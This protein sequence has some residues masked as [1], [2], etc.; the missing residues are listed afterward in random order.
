MV[1]VLSAEEDGLDNIPE[2][3]QCSEL[4]ENIEAAASSLSNS[5]G[6]I[7]DAISCLEEAVD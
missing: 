5:V 1:F 3:L 4:Y 7:E 2:N 6:F